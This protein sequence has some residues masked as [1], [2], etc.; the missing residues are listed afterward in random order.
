MTN[1]PD[2]IAFA[3]DF[4]EAPTSCNHILRELAHTRRVLWLNSVATRTPKLSSPRDRGRIGRKLREFA[5]GPINVE[6]GLWIFT[7]IVLPFPHSPLARRINR[8]ILRATVRILRARLRISDFQL[9]TFIPTVA[10]YLGI[11]GE[12]LI[13][14]YCVDEFSMFSNIDT[15]PVLAAE[16]TLLERADCVFA[17]TPAL[18]D[19]KRSLNPNTHLS[20]HGV[21][22]AFFS[23]ALDPMTIIPADLASLPH[24]VIGFYGTIADWVDLDLVAY[25][26]R[27]HP[28]WSLVMI[29]PVMVDT[30]AVRGF[31]NVHLLGRREHRDLPSYCKGFDVGLIPYRLIDRMPFVNPIKL[32]EYLSAGL[33]VVST[34]VPEVRRYSSWCLVGESHEE[35]RL[36]I[37]RALRE[38]SPE[39]RRARSQAMESE[40]W[41]ARVDEIERIVRDTALRKRGNR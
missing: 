11:L 18:A 28:E 10:D 38:D 23:R 20:P 24:P 3:K 21:D 13:V 41:Q 5:R 27:S 8:Q 30:A 2:I 1:A 9:W 26:A 22:H 35:V 6:N 15:A 17:V 36:A 14:Y 37:E 32:R 7:P 40:T 34:A 16:K 25:L 31:P 39:K 29:G 12:S 19:R 4:G 33:P